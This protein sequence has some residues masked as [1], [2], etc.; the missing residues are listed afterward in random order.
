[1]I[2][3][4]DFT[5]VTI[6]MTSHYEKVTKVEKINNCTYIRPKINYTGDIVFA[7]LD[8]NHSNWEEFIVLTGTVIK[9]V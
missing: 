1:M 8:K 6:V 5:S 7:C 4:I 3:L 2:A 9:D